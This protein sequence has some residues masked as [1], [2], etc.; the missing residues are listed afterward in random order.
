MRVEGLGF[1][2]HCSVEALFEGLGLGVEGLG[3]RHHD[4]VKA[5]FEG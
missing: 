3:F 2:H 1:R 4:N 5:L